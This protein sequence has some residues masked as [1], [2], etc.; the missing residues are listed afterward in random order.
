M[1]EALEYHGHP[2][3]RHTA[4]PGSKPLVGTDVALM[5]RGLLTRGNKPS[6]TQTGREVLE[7]LSRQREIGVQDYVRE[8]TW[9]TVGVAL[10]VRGDIVTV[11]WST[12]TTESVHCRRLIK[13]GG[14]HTTP[15]APPEPSATVTL[16]RT[17]LVQLARLVTTWQ[18]TAELGSSSDQRASA[19]LWGKL[20]MAQGE[21]S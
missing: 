2:D 14:H 20:V 21:C 8:L 3:P 16:T 10:A 4:R 6:L 12:D 1:C 15:V 18:Q 5:E 13:L 19:A 17:E 11:R 9:S 7:T